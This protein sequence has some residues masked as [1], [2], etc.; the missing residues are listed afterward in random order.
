MDIMMRRAQTHTSSRSP[1]QTQV[2]YLE[3]TAHS[4]EV[5]REV[6]ENGKYGSFGFTLIQE[7]PS[8]VG[9]VVSGKL[10]E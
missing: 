7:K 4:V 6:K 10:Y 3:Q 5:R 2:A 9:T 1:P 8:I